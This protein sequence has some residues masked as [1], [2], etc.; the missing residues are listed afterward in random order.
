MAVHKP[1]ALRPGSKIG[2]VA[3]AGCVDEA[4]LGAGAATLR[5][6]GFEV[7]FSPST[8]AQKGYLAG[9]PKARAP[10]LIAF[11]H[12]GDIDAIFCARGG[13]GAIQTLPYLDD[14][15]RNRPKIFAGYSD[16]TVLLN[17]LLQ[18]FEMV[19]FHA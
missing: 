18:R 15:I 10:D 3:P 11:F 14:E 4:A 12:R 19:T 8:R 5:A 7:E 2:V 17:W 13:F 9:D 6:K 16:I 1:S